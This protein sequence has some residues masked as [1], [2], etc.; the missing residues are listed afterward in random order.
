MPSSADVVEDAPTSEEW[1]RCNRASRRAAL[2][3]YVH[4]C[5]LFLGKIGA[6][7]IINVYLI[8]SAR[9]VLEAR[10]PI[11]QH[12]ASQSLKPDSKSSVCSLQ[13]FIGI[14]IFCVK[15][16]RRFCVSGAYL[17]CIRRHASDPVDSATE[18]TQFRT[19]LFV[20]TVNEQ[21]ICM[22]PFKDASLCATKQIGICS[23]SQ[24]SIR[25]GE[26]KLSKLLWIRKLKRK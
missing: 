10:V 8:A 13:G 21:C 5:K 16:Y 12:Q 2:S 23:A 6:M 3:A 14:M 4:R 25:V 18:R 26:T 20:T 17:L 7:F 19:F 11:L 22:Q 1:H 15:A 9:G 24:K